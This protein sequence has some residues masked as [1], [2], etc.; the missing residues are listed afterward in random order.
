MARSVVHQQEDLTRE[1][2]SCQVP[3]HLRDKTVVEPIHEDGSHYPRLSIGPQ[4]YGQHLIV[5]VLESMR[6]QGMIQHHGF[7]L[8][9]P[10]RS[11]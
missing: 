4:K 9:D 1:V 3:L 5:F 10:I 2:L 11:P 6:V 8:L 7:Y